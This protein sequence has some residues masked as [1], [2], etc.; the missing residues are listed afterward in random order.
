MYCTI[1]S[2]CMSAINVMYINW[3]WKQASWLLVAILE[4]SMKITYSDYS[5]KQHIALLLSSL[6]PWKLCSSIWPSTSARLHLAFHL[7]QWLF[8]WQVCMLCYCVLPFHTVCHLLYRNHN[9]PIPDLEVIHRLQRQICLEFCPL[10]RTWRYV[11]R[12][13][14]TPGMRLYISNKVN[15]CIV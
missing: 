8:S 14:L 13:Y 6:Q 10:A 9:W 3:H 2:A 7:T 12:Q 15:A 4:I 1:A 11:G 5:F